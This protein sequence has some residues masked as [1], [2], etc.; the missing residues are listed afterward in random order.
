MH[1]SKSRVLALV[2]LAAVA[3]YVVGLASGRPGLCLGAKPAP[4]LCLAL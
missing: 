2:G 1:G 4:G 3:A